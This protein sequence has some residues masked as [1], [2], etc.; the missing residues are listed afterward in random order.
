AQVVLWD[1]ESQT[2]RLGAA[3]GTEME[4]VKTQQF[5]VGEGVNGL[6]AQTR[7]PLIVNDYQAFPQRV[8]GLT[9][10]GAVIGVPLLYRDRLLGVLTSHATQS[11]SAFTP[12]HLALLTNFADQAAVAIENARL[13]QEIQQH[14][15]EL[16]ERVRQRTRELDEAS[17]HKS[18]LLA[19]MS[20]ELRTPLNSIIGFAEFL[21][22]ERLG[23]LTEKQT[24][25]LGHIRA[26]GKHLLELI[27]DILDLSKAEAGRIVLQPEDL[28]VP[29]TLEDILV[30]TR[31][32]AHQKNQT[33]EAEIQPDMPSLWADPIRFKQILFNLLSNAVK[34][35]PGGGR[36][37]ITA[38]QVSGLPSSVP[39]PEPAP[40]TED[41]GPETGEA[42]LEIKVS[43]T[44]IGIKAEDLPRLFQQ[45]VQLEAS[46]TKHHEGTGLG[47]ALAKRL[48][49]LH[50][51]RI[52]AESEGEGQGSTFTVVL[53]FTQP[54]Q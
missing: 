28:S 33:V 10:V 8:N 26:S 25:F 16:E 21:Q 32:L 30:T 14:A 41:R 49:E 50:G 34:F 37:S 19:N 35:T 6:V 13:Y 36:I 48:V 47:L 2:L 51:G 23:S 18:E 9:H 24:R 15:A 31:G 22:E 46:A 3:Y 7:K 54:S 12:D 39:R 45:F 27:G 38:R 52:W 29:T 44:G 43:D 5:R 53:P 20:H 40:A 11:G 42:R 1:E 17:R 4:R